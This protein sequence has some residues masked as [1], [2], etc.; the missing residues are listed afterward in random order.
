MTRA[1][2]ERIGWAL[3][4][5]DPAPHE[6]VLEI[7]CGPGVAAA[8]VCDRLTSGHLTAIDRS[9]TAID[10]ARRRAEAHVTSG[11][12]RLHQ[13]ALAD[14][15]AA[16]GEAQPFDAAFAVDVNTFWTGPADAESAVLAAAV[17]PEGRVLL[18]YGGPGPGGVRD[19]APTVAAN[20]GRHGFTTE[21][22]RHPGGALLCVDAR[23]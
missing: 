12:L 22:V 3:E 8:L 11:R 4:L 16:S 20:L 2:P 14:L 17:R 5:L 6:E 19:V 13:V 23:R 18:V 10:R 21:V 9:A 1:V 7:G 15:P